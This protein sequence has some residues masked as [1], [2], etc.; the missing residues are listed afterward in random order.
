M[1]FKLFSERLHNAFGSK[2]KRYCIHRNRAVGLKFDIYEA[3]I[4]HYKKEHHARKEKD[5][6]KKIQVLY[7]VQK[8]KIPIG[9]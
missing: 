6:K 7:D 3:N 4:H 1:P 9:S 5:T 8:R 2:T